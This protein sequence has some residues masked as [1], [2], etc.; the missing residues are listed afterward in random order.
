ML[1]NPLEVHEYETV[2]KAQ[3]D[4]ELLNLNGLGDRKPVVLLRRINALNDHPQTLKRAI[5]LSNVPAR[6]SQH[7]YQSEFR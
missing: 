7:R 5:Y 4:N 1:I 6:R 2:K 3:R